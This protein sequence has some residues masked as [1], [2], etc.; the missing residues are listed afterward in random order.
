MWTVVRV[1]FHLLLY[2]S[3]GPDLKTTEVLSSSLVTLPSSS[4]CSDKSRGERSYL[5]VFP[6]LYDPSTF[7]FDFFVRRN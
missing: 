4:L 5:K 6:F 1:S 3:D 7:F 2:L